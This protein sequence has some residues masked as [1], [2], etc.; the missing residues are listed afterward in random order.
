MEIHTY[1]RNCCEIVI[2]GNRE[3]TIFHDTTRQKWRDTTF[4][5]HSETITRGGECYTNEH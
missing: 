5:L 1:K 2:N 3:N 4:R